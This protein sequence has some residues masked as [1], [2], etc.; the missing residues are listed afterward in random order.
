MKKR[1][2]LIILCVAAVISVVAGAIIC[3]LCFRPEDNNPDLESEEVYRPTLEEF[4]EVIAS[5]EN[6]DD[7]YDGLG[8]VREAA[9]VFGDEALDKLGYVFEDVNDDGKEE[10]FIGCFEAGTSEGVNNDIYAAFTHDG[11]E[12]IPLFEKQKRN[13][14]ALTDTGTVYF[15]GSDEKDYYIL[16]EYE[17]T[18]T[19]LVCKDFYF[20]YPKSTGESRSFGYYHNTTGEWDPE[21]SEELQMTLDEFEELRKELAKRTVPLDDVKF[22]EVGK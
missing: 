13:T 15:Y 21:G 20:T 3:F 12:L 9:L 11:N 4:Y 16:A 6:A 5:P 2:W 22:S 17:L 14:F 8:C 7:L 18:D 10:V 19:G 1:V